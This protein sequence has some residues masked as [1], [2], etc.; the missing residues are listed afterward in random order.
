MTTAETLTTVLSAIAIVVSVAA[1]LNSRRESNIADQSAAATI[2]NQMVV[3]ILELDKIHL[4]NPKV[5]TFFYE[6]RPLDPRD[7][8]A[9]QVHA[10]AEITLDTFEIVLAQIRLNPN[11]FRTA[12]PQDRR[13]ITDSFQHSQV[14][15]DDFDAHTQWYG[16]DLLTLRKQACS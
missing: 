1:Y 15:R 4:N 14:L 11:R 6:N 5:R 16:S 9:P 8:L 10:I 7:E 3:A 13:W 2:Y 12:E